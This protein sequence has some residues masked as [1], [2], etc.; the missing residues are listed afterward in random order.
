MSMAAREITSSFVVVSHTLAL[1]DVLIMAP[2]IP[3]KVVV[4]VLWVILDTLPFSL[5][6]LTSAKE[7]GAPVW[8]PD[9]TNRT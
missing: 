4:E 1:A 5:N 3:S 7:K 8:V 6:G 2:L 9:A